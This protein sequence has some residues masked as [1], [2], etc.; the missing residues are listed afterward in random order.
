MHHWSLHTFWNTLFSWFMWPHIFLRIFYL[1]GCS[2]SSFFARVF[3]L[4]QSLFLECPRAFLLYIHPPLQVESPICIWTIAKCQ[5]SALSLL[6][7]EFIRLTANFTSSLRHQTHISNWTFPMW[8]SQLPCLIPA[9][10]ISENGGIVLLATNHKPRQ[11]LI[12]LL[13]ISLTGKCIIRS[14]LHSTAPA[15]APS[16]LT[17]ITSI[18][19]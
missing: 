16:S 1:T 13:L 18:T 2:F 8:N 5:V 4:A 15:P 6:S 14:C 11:F 9:L 19:F 3:F 17:C 10:F 7:Y 12:T